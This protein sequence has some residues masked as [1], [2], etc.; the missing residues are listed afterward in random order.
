MIM[1]LSPD[2]SRYIALKLSGETDQNIATAI[3]VSRSTIVLW[4]QIPEFR[5]TLVEESQKVYED[6]FPALGSLL[7]TAIASLKT[8]LETG[9]N[10]EKLRATQ[11]LLDH[12]AK[13]SE[14]ATE[15]RIAIIEQKLDRK[16]NEQERNG[17]EN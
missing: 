1:E 16:K 2:Q 4:K 15:A 9:N 7:D 11:I 14:R 8:V 17:K 13:L 3:G 6:S 5:A 12:L 10:S